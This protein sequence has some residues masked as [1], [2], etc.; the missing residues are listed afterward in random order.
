MIL[1]KARDLSETFYSYFLKIRQKS[2]PNRV[3]ILAATDVDSVCAVKILLHL[4]YCDQ[5]K[6]SLV[7][8]TKF[9]DCIAAVQPVRDTVRSIIMI[10]CGAAEDV[11]GLLNA[12]DHVRFFILDSR[13]PVHIRNLYSDKQ[14]CVLRTMS[15]E[16][17]GHLPKYEEVFRD[18]D[19]NGLPDALEAKALDDHDEVMSQSSDNSQTDRHARAKEDREKKRE[20]RKWNAQRT[21]VEE[22]YYRH[23]YYQDSSAV[24]M[25]ELAHLLSKDDQDLF[26]WAVIGLCDM[27]MQRRIGSTEFVEV[28]SP[29]LGNKTTVKENFFPSSLQL[30]FFSVFKEI[31]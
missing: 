1:D 30:S 25:F 14:V 24:K 5:I 18:V 7:V 13:M 23:V 22:R 27:F 9:Q 20:F 19:E 16:D 31:S 2:S 3:L 12:N 4:F 29:D 11:V 6:Y 28:G 10:N 21:V 26:F 15:R 17:I 8:C